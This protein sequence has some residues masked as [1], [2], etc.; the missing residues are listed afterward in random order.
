MLESEG[1][2]TSRVVDVHGTTD[3]AG[4]ALHVAEENKYQGVL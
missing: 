1:S 2:V 4:L 3:V